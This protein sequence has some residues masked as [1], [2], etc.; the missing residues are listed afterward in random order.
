V[1]AGS[2]ITL[3]AEVIATSPKA[4]PTGTITFQGT[5]GVVPGTVAYSTVFNTTTGN[6]DLL[7]TITYT[8]AISDS[9]AA[10][11]SGDA[12][13]A[14]ATGTGGTTI[15]VGNDFTLVFP[16]PSVT[17]TPGQYTQINMIVG[18]QSTT[19]PVTFSA[20]P[21]S[22][23]PAE[24][25]CG[26]NSATV[27]YTYEDLLNLTTTAPHAIAMGS[28]H[29][30]PSL[31]LAAALAFPVLGGLLLFVA[32]TRKCRKWTTCLALLALMFLMTL[33]SC[34]GSSSGTGGSGGGGGGGGG[35]DPGT[36]AGTYTITVTATSGSGSAAITHT[37]T[38]NLIVQ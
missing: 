17:L 29:E 2:S 28:R 23:L 34:G 7:A 13:Y 22:G 10:Q 20:T 18:L 11:Y 8:P 31:L 24:S 3:S 15:V 12:N 33:P 37:A 25:T 19:S 4:V 30:H 14:A 21:C 38:F 36:P 5:N 9:Y 27:T 26:A 35:T 6:T 1:P 16:Q 32:P